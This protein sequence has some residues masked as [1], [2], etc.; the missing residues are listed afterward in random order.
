VPVLWQLGGE[1]AEIG[2]KC[3]TGRSAAGCPTATKR[4]ITDSL[5]NTCPSSCKPTD[6]AKAA[7]LAVA[8]KRAFARSAR[9]GC[10]P[11]TI[12]RAKAAASPPTDTGAKAAIACPYRKLHPS[13]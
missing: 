10:T 13:D 12:R 9:S 11:A 7:S 6:R 1:V 5:N 3:A 8:N 2:T 4:S